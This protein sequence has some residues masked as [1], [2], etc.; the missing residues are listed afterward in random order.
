M[1]GETEPERVGPLARVAQRGALLSGLTL[2]LVQGTSLLST[3]I[4]A[5][6]LSPEEVGLYAAGTV[7]AGFLTVAT[8]G[9]LRAALVQRQTRIDDAADTVFYATAASGLVMSL[10]ALASAPLISMIF[11]NPAAGEI[12]AVTSGMLVMHG[13]TNVP[14]GL[15]QRRF[16]FRRRLIVDP[17]RSVTFGVVTIACAAG[18]L[19]VYALVFG[20][21]ASTGAWLAGT[22]LLARW[23]PGR[24]RPSITLWRELA[25]FAYPLVVQNVVRNLRGSTQAALVGRA[26]GEAALGQ[27]RYGRRLGELPGT[28]VV[29]IGSY[30][31]FPAFA[32]LAGEPDRLLQ[33]FLRAL[34]W[35]WFGA[36]PATALLVTLGEPAVVVLL[37]ERWRDAGTFMVA[38]A[39]YGAGVAVQSVALEAIRGS[40]RSRLLN[41][42]SAAQLVLGVGLVLALM[43][44]GLVG[45]GLAISAASLV[46][47][48]LV[49]ALARTVVPFSVRDLVRLL[50]PP[51]TGAL[52]ASVVV[53]PLER[54]VL[55]AAGH[56]TTLGIVILLGHVLA[57]AVVYVAVMLPL[58][59]A[60]IQEAVR[61][62]IALLRRL[63]RAGDGPSGQT[64]RHG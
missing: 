57:F 24:G 7:L 56:G 26:L 32:R 10:V 2:V 39:G 6:L 63:S 23:R 18:G 20:N 47:A 36:A 61:R 19:G 17:L 59:R 50:V 42:V 8:E 51:A 43:P 49:L 31:L 62:T 44:L 21:Y 9:G 64:E 25:R 33:A 3:L 54:F 38:M 11:R 29:E 40:G 1:S 30:V 48:V 41:W 55:G 16:N 22:W 60:A 4:L 52:V 45:V 5:R 37:G 34:R 13:F 46:V 53:G 14:D 28:A 12:A 15:M 27:Y 35:V 58:D